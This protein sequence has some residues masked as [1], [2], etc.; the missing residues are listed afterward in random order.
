[1]TAWPEW[2]AG[3]TPPVETQNLTV[4][5]EAVAGLAALL[6]ADPALATAGAAL[7]LLW[8]WVALAV[9]PPMRTVG[10]DGHPATGGF[11]PP[12]PYPRRMWLGVSI[13]AATPP[14]IGSRV[15]VERTVSDITE[16]S[17]ASGSFALV[18]VITT[19]RAADGAPLIVE[20]TRF[21]YRPATEITPSTAAVAPTSVLEGKWLTGSGSDWTATPE[22]V[23]LARYSALTANGHRIHY[24]LPYATQVEGYPNLLVHGPLMA[25]VVA[26]VARRSRP[27]RPMVRFS[28]RAQRPYFLGTPASVAITHSTDDSVDLELSNDL[29]AGPNL[30]ATAT[31]G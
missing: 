20:T 16:K 1:M 2:A 17:G 5:A 6:D 10:P 3:W 24:D 23:V 15:S 9:W 28:C 7:P 18:T 29:A 30:T 12:A 11:M 27:D 26:E 8:H 4:S 22:P 25:T 14:T 21:A 13:E 31:F 19:V